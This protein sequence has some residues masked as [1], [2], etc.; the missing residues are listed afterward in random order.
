[1]SFKKQGVLGAL[2]LSALLSAGAARANGRLPASNAFAFH[3]TTPGTIYMRTTFG[4]LVAKDSGH[5][6]DWICERSLGLSGPEDPSL[7]VFADGTVATTT[8]EGLGVTHDGACTFAFV[9]GDLANANFVDIAVRKDTYTAA[10]VITS[11][12]ANVTDDAGNAYF[13]SKVFTSQDSGKTWAKKGAD[14]DQTILPETVDWSQADPTRVYVSG[15]RG[16]GPAPQGVILV[17]D[18]G[19]GTFV[20]RAVPLVGKERAPFIAALDPQNKDIVYVRT[21][22]SQVDPARLLMS[23]DGA[24]T[25]TVA[26]TS[27]GPLQ[28][29]A[30]SDDGTKVFVGGPSDGLYAATA[31]AL[32]F[33]KVSSLQVQCLGYQQ[34][35]LWACSNEFSGFT[36]GVSTD[37][38]K[39]FEP[40]L[41]LSDVR[42]P[43]SCPAGTPTHELCAADW[44]T[45]QA[46]LGIT[47]GGDGGAADRDAGA[48]AGPATQL[49]A[50]GG[51]GCSMEL[52]AG[53]SG[54]A[55]A[56]M[57]LSLLVLGARRRARRDRPQTK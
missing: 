35:Q 4:A 49:G 1:M 50:G 38:G 3:P 43:L 25:W 55:G 46:A 22:G 45:Q 42:G 27:K 32:S 2:A 47:L 56:A 57:G 14:L 24:K 12:F 28:G 44:P 18:D 37:D 19:G 8:F 31:K 40:R 7:G 17:S 53:P 5:S 20:E 39:T 23:T 48:D 30:L 9:G 26:F 29:F 33:A 13:T 34:G 36:A 6:W 21:N 52:L 54:L 11:N 10:I 16:S 51:G 15:A 41:H